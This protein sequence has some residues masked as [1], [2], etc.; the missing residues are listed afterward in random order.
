LL[1]ELNKLKEFE[2]IDNNGGGGGES[3]EKIDLRTDKLL[4]ELINQ[5]EN[6]L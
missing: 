3:G 4:N 6:I 1:K 5:V 2:I